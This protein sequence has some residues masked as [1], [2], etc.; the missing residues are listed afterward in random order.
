MIRILKHLS[1]CILLFISA[2]QGKA[3][4]GPDST[5]PYSEVPE[6][7]ENYNAGTVAARMLDGL[8][9]RFY[10]ATEGLQKEDFDFR[11]GEDSRSV[12]ETID[13]IYIMTIMI[14]NAVNQLSDGPEEGISVEEKRASVLKN[15]HKI[16]K[17][18]KNSSD[19]DFESFNLKFA[20][21][22]ELPFWNLIN[23]PIADC[24]WH[25]GQIVTLRRMSGNPFNPD[26]SLLNGKL[27]K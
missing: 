21:G 13:H 11:A 24:I 15:I 26:V 1:I 20:N 27:R 16:N 6:Y 18:L 17:K 12:A 5:L 10:W 8:G 2:V 19:E 9:F 23:G 14:S 7:A 3:Q 25:C 22:N 4:E